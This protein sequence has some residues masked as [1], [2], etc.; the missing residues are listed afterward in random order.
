[1]QMAADI[2]HGKAPFVYDGPAELQN[3]LAF[4][5][6]MKTLTTTR[7]KLGFAEQY[8]HS[9]MGIHMDP[10]PSLSFEAIVQKDSQQCVADPNNP[11]KGTWQTKEQWQQAT[12]DTYWNQVF[13]H[14]FG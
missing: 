5:N 14:E 10:P 4:A 8:A 1:H 3:A 7:R 13:W 11:G 12:V 9:A 6:Q 2:D